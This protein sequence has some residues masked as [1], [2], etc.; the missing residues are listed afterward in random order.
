VPKVKV[1]Y[2]PQRDGAFAPLLEPGQVIEV[3]FGEAE[4]LVA[5][6]AFVRDEPEAALEAPVDSAPQ[7]RPR[8][9]RD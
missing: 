5:T 1:R 7:T 8:K 2:S 4:H 9:G 3:T 6:G